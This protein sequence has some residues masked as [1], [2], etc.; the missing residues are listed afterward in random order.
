MNVV[1][2]LKSKDST[3]YDAEWVYKLQRAVERN[4][5]IPHQF[6]CFSDIALDCKYIELAEDFSGWWNK[7]QVFNPEFFLGETLY[8]DLDV[9]ITKSIDELISNLRNSQSNLFMCKE[10]TGVS[11]SS[12]MYW[13]S[14]VE[15]LY[16]IYK[17]DPILYHEKYKTIPLIGDQAF[18]S[19]NYTHDYIEN[20]LSEGYISWTDSKSLNL[21][22]NTGLIVFTSIKSKPSKRIFINNPVIKQHWI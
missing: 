5:S 21:N 14:P 6:V 8:F 11:N 2:V 22:S 10:P 3:I 19:E 1:C 16:E 18:I 13:K 17:K 12:I 7:I 4:L 15:N 20:Y 9:V